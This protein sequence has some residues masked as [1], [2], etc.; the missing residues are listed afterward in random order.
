MLTA[1]LI[2]TK[3]PIFTLDSDRYK[4]YGKLFGIQTIGKDLIENNN[5]PEIIFKK[6]NI[7]I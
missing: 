6:A 4:D 5:S 1:I 2:E 3:L 7:K